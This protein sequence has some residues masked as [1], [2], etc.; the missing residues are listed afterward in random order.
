MSVSR[1]HT[2]NL[3]QPVVE[4]I[5]KADV[6]VLPAWVGVDMPNHGGFIVAKIDKV[7]VSSGDKLEDEAARRQI[8]QIIQPTLSKAETDAFVAL[9]RTQFKAKIMAP[10]PAVEQAAPAAVAEAEE[11][12]AS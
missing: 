10:K 11:A 9:L 2:Q 4:A 6:S 1:Q 8:E 7:Q 5:L 12:D 3:P